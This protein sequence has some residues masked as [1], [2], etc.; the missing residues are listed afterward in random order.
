MYDSLVAS[1]NLTPLDELKSLDQQIDQIEALPDLQP[2]YARLEEITKEHSGNFEVQLVAHD[3][4]QH[5][6]TRGSRLKQLVPPPLVVAPP[7]ATPTPATA[8]P[9]AKPRRRKGLLWAFAALLFAAAAVI[10]VNV[11]RDRAARLAAAAPVD[12]KITTLPTGAAVVIEGQPGCTSDCATKL[13]PGTYAVTATLLGYE[14]ATASLIVAPQQPASLA[15]TLVAQPISVRVFADL[16]IGKVFLD[17]QPAGDLLDGQFTLERLEPG[18]HAMRVTGGNREATFSI[19][20]APAGLPAV[21]RLI[22]TRNIFAVVVTNLG[23]KARLF[24]SSGPLTLT[25]N[26]QPEADA[27]PDG[28]DLTNFHTGPM[29]FAIG[30]GSSQHTLPATFGTAPTLT[31]F[32]KTDQKIGTLLITTGQDDVRIF[33]NNREHQRRTAKGQAR[34]QTFGEVTV[35]VEK[36]GFEPAPPQTATVK[37]GVETK[38]T[39]TL[40]ALPQFAGLSISGLAAGTQVLLDQRPLGSPGSDGVFHSIAPG[41]HTIEIRR[42]QFEPKRLTRTFR[43]GET[44][45]I[46]ISDATLVAVKPPPPAPTVAPPPVARPET[47]APKPPPKTRASGTMA[48]FDTPAAWQQV[49]GVWRHRGAATLTYSVTP[50]GIFTFSI[51]ML[52][53]GGILRGGRVRWVFNYVDAKNY[54]LFELDEENFWA[55]VV[56]NGKTLERKKVAHRQDKTMRVWNIQIDASNQ[57][58]VHKIQGDTGWV[59]L[60]SWSEPSRDF[61]TG[62]FG[63]LV[64]GTDEVGLSNFTFTGR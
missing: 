18:T 32:L 40:K 43:A 1:G 12:A 15:L 44:L 31:A 49:D 34:I 37:Q 13:A 33:V 55:K 20:A 57:R 6:L 24:T 7:V 41:E 39:F 22:Q 16:G 29:E 26:G 59:D 52:K 30:E 3:V 5:M 27:T 9:P 25:S 51:Y 4:K 2:I 42:D 8:Q 47:V 46:G 64:T 62:K 17:G 21:D 19:V 45:V 36:P 23:E 60:D 58:L 63:I 56:Q 28:I 38:L 50:D 53:G 14:P 54:A 11:Q 61:T 35:R 48:N 10:G